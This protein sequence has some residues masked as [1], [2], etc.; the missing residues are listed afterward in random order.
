MCVNNRCREEGEKEEV[1]EEEDRIVDG[2]I[3]RNKYAEESE[4]AGVK[5]KRKENS[6]RGSERCWR[7]ESETAQT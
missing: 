2:K 6:G 1:E 5:K 7:G 4:R 3:F